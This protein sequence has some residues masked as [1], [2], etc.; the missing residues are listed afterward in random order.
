MPDRWKVEM[1]PGAENWRVACHEAGHAVAALLLG[2]P[3]AAVLFDGGGGATTPETPPDP[4]ISPDFKIH[5]P[6]RLHGRWT[7]RSMTE[8]LDDTVV[9]A[10][11]KVAEGIVVTHAAGPGFVVVTGPDGQMIESAAVEA[12]DRYP[13]I[14][15]AN[16]WRQLAV[17]CAWRLLRPHAGSLRAIASELQQRRSLTAADV[18]RI[19]AETQ[20]RKE[21]TPCES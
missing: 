2:H 9:F 8:I 19:H 12:L 10:S 6:E 17:A 15:A 11:G 3:M 21:P 20:N 18:A 16:A 14:E 7:G 1:T 5:T 13:S 4:A